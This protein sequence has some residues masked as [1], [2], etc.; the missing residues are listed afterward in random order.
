[1]WIS[2]WASGRLGTHMELWGLG[3]FKRFFFA[4]TVQSR[5]IRSIKDLEMTV[6]LVILNISCTQNR[7]VKILWKNPPKYF[8]TCVYL[9][10]SKCQK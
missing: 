1:M 5:L 10:I 7:D 4:L 2:H 3:H 9:M 8:L 6:I